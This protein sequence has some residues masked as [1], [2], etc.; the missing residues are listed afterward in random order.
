MSTEALI[1]GWSRSDW[2]IAFITNGI[3]V[4]LMLESTIVGQATFANPL[5]FGDVGIVEI[6]DVRNRRAH[7]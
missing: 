5:Q 4:N 3:I 2:A 7:S 1:S 6:R